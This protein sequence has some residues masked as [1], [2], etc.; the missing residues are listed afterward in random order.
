MLYVERYRGELKLASQRLCGLKEELKEV[1]IASDTAKQILDRLESQINGLETSF[2]R[3]RG[4]V[5]R[6]SRPQNSQGLGMSCLL[7]WSY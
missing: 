3:P 1:G 6:A 7:I 2:R 5:R 4:R